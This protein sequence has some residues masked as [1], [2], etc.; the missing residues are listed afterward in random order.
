M[1][2]DLGRNQIWDEWA[3]LLVNERKNRLQ[4]WMALYLRNTWIWD[5]WA[6]VIA[7]KIKLKDWVELDL[8]SNIA[9]HDEWKKAL[10]ECVK[11]HR[12]QWI[13]C[14]ILV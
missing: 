14:R 12:A 1:T 9:I 3:N 13:N 8:T 11:R 5:E 7:Q 10:Q 6:K 4:P 2:L